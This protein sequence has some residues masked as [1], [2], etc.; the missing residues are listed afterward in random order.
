MDQNPRALCRAQ[1]SL[2]R[3]AFGLTV[4]RL[5]HL[6]VPGH[7]MIAPLKQSKVVSTAPTPFTSRPT[8][9]DRRSS[10]RSTSHKTTRNP[11]VTASPTILAGKRVEKPL[12]LLLAIAHQD[13]NRQIWI[14]AWRDLQDFILRIGS[15]R[16]CL[17]LLDG[18]VAVGHDND[19]RLAR[20]PP[21]E[22]DAINQKRAGDA[23]HQDVQ[24]KGNPDPQVNLEEDFA[25]S[26]TL[27]LPQP[28]LPSAHLVVSVEYGYITFPAQN[29][30]RGPGAGSTRM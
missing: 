1:L 15:L 19:R 26:S 11:G 13:L 20:K 2:L 5:R 24:A 29:E 30:P 7:Q 14:P 8:G 28:P 4:S 16:G 12:D 3:S 21:G 22:F 9:R 10:W 27:G 25:Q 6:P 23:H 18:Q 17:Q